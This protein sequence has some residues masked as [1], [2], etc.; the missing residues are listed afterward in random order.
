MLPNANELSLMKWS[1][2]YVKGICD[3]NVCVCI[4]VYIFL[5][6]K[7]KMLALNVSYL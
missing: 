6:F 5:Y 4:N 3:V 7:H 2:E 1:N